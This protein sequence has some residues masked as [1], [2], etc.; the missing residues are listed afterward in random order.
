MTLS[1]LCVAAALLLASVGV[2]LL[3]W[4]HCGWLRLSQCDFRSRA[5]VTAMKVSLSLALFRPHLTDLH[6]E[7]PAPNGPTLRA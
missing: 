7:G 4:E 2:C 3:C 6:S 1:G 5:S